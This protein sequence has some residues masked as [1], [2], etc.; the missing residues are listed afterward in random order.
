MELFCVKAAVHYY[1]SLHEFSAAFNLRDT[2]LILT[3]SVIYDTLLQPLQLPCNVI[4]KDTYSREEP[5]EETVDAIL[6]D[7]GNMHVE[8]VIAIGGG[9]VIDIAKVICVKDAYPIRRV[10]NHEVPAVHDKTLIVLPSTCGTG[11]EVT[12]GGIITMKD[13]GFKTAIMDS[14]LVSAHA[15]LVPELLDNLPYPVFAY[16]SVD[17]LAHSMEAYVS[18]TRGNEFARAVGARS[19]KILTEGY[20]ELAV[21]GKEKKRELQKSFI[22]ASC[23]GGMAV[24]NGGAGPIHALAYPLGEVYHMSHG[25]SIYQFLPEVFCFYEQTKGG[26]LLQE[27]GEILKQSLQKAGISC[28]SPFEG[29]GVLLNQVQ[30]RRPLSACGMKEEDIKP[31]TENIFQ[32][33]QRL[34]AASYSTFT[35]EDAERI[36][37]SRL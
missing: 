15:V 11:S 1:D 3:E 36:Y 6:K 37:R 19:V 14:T 16:C 5:N 30:P 4:L 24:N 32:A 29:L 2:D 35:K 13:T 28:E 34:L 20:A 27:L 31:F 10:M 9:S 7:M 17:A 23:L 18:A 33:K 26:K 25:E 8:R 12:Y 22:M 21:H